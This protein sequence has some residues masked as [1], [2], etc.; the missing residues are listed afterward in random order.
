[1]KPLFFQ[2]KKGWMVSK[3]EKPQ[4]ILLWCGA[5]QLVFCP[6]NSSVWHSVADGRLYNILKKAQAR[7]DR[8]LAGICHK[9]KTTMDKGGA[10]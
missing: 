4:P 5:C 2:T 9:C 3:P 1:V 10:P 8:L 6:A 7:G